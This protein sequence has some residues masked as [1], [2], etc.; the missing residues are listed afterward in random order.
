MACLFMNI[1]LV[2]VF[3]VFRTEYRGVGNEGRSVAGRENGEEE[4]GGNRTGRDSVFSVE[5]YLRSGKS[6]RSKL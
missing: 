6:K 1:R 2:V 4:E 5:E 3:S